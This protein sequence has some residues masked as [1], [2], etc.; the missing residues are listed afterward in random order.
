LVYVPGALAIGLCKLLGFSPLS[1]FLGVRLANFCVFLVAGAAA[2]R[3]ASRGTVVMAC[4]LLLPM[5]LGLAASCSQD[6]LLI[7]AA[8][9]AVACL[10]RV[11]GAPAPMAARWFWLAVTLL[12]GVALAK[13]PYA[14]LGLLLLI[15][16][17]RTLRAAFGVLPG[18]ALVVVPAAAWSVL[19]GRVAVVTRHD[20]VAEAGPLWPGERPAL[21][22]GPDIGAQLHVLAAHPWAL[23]W[24][25]LH[26]V[27]SDSGALV[28]QAVGILD[29]L[30]LDLP[31]WIYYVWFV[32]LGCAIAAEWF[33]G[34]RAARWRFGDAVL[35]G[36]AVLL[37]VLSIGIALYLQWT[38]VGMAWIGGIEGRYF[39]PL[40]PGVVLGLPRGGRP[41]LAHGFAA[42]VLIAAAVD[43]AVLPGLVAA[44]YPLR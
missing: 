22:T 26:S 41:R 2:L 37:T 31:G 7:A 40:L 24:L 35:S 29:Y 43:A 13:P 34:G 15:P 32:A 3:I 10:T 16:V 4:T 25:P 42:V 6:G 36:V 28:R 12:A 8:A 44:F 17:R 19:E 27:A 39:L 30:C 18:V 11:E 38:P 5:S 21:F 20:A 14:P 33:G 23:V 1:A 9:L